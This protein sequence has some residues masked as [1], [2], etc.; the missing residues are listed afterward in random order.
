[1]TKKRCGFKS[2]SF[3]VYP[4]R[5]EGSAAAPEGKRN[6]QRLLLSHAGA[7]ID[8]SSLRSSG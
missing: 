4:E 1:M 8:P 3:G 5:S 6:A 2:Y 7:V